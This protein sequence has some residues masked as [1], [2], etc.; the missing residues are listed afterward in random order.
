MRGARKVV[1][2][3]HSIQQQARKSRSSLSLPL[4]DVLRS[5]PGR[6]GSGAATGGLCA[7]PSLAPSLDTSK[8]QHGKPRDLFFSF[9]FFL[10]FRGNV[11]LYCRYVHRVEAPLLRQEEKGEPLFIMKDSRKNA[12]T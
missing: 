5:L 6:R 8:Q 12:L 3:L 1:N 7:S 9:L 10:L 4:L 11:R 2:S